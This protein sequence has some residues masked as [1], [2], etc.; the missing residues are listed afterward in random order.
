MQESLLRIQDQTDRA[1]ELALTL[2]RFDLMHL[3]RLH[4]WLLLVAD[5]RAGKVRAGG[6]HAGSRQAQVT[7]AVSIEMKVTTRRE[8]ASERREV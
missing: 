1:N 8:R 2:L 6:I 4:I 7:A 3:V 5:A